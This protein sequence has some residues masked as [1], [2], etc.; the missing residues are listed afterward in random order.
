M[1]VA[2][3]QLRIDWQVPVVAV[4]MLHVSV[5]VL[6]RRSFPYAP[7][8]PRLEGGGHLRWEGLTRDERRTFVSRRGKHVGC[9]RCT[10]D[11]IRFDADGSTPGR[12]GYVTTL[13]R[14]I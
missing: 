3:T 10:D 8:L 6:L 2:L 11:E 9:W 12:F 1:T 14:F 4:C 13:G 5:G 7:P